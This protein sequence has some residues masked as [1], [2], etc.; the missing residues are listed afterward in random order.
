MTV[1]TSINAEQPKPKDLEIAEKRPSVP[2][3]IDGDLKAGQV[4]LLDEA[5]IFLQQNGISHAQMRELFEDE[6]AKKKLVRKVFTS[7]TP[8]SPIQ[9]TLYPVFHPQ[10]RKTI[11]T[12][13]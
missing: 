3:S 6:D 9:E 7:F 4:E 11:T 8:P 2:G 5:E 13:I 1:E 10:H 12:T